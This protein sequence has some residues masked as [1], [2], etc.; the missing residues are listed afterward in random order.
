MN[1]KVYN[2]IY[3]I[4]SG[5]IAADLGNTSVKDIIMKPDFQKI[6]SILREKREE[7]S[8]SIIDISDKLCIRK[9]LVKALE[10]GN[11]A[12]LPHEVYIRG[13]LKKYAQLLDINEDTLGL[14]SPAKEP[15]EI[16]VKN[17]APQKPAHIHGS[18]HI[19]RRAMLIPLVFVL[20]IAFFVLNQ[21]YKERSAT[22]STPDQIAQKSPVSTKQAKVNA[23]VNASQQPGGAE[24]SQALSVSEVKKLMITCNERTW[25]SVVIDDNEKKE[26]MLNPEEMIVL[27]ARDNFDILVGNAAGVKL[28]LNG[29]EV[30]F[31]G[32]SGEVKRVKVS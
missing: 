1:R 22:R 20:I 14:D 10:D 11:L 27:N 4:Q 5:A 32:K 28:N 24:Q 30:D 6:G 2:K 16:A 19:A 31:T 3:K 13:Y 15:A 25:V 17:S 29:K 12:L 18:R 23:S 8:L 7:K 21:I 9:S 26:F